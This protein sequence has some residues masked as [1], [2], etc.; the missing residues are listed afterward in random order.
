MAG[1]PWGTDTYPSGRFGP[2]QRFATGITSGPALDE[3]AN[4]AP[5]SSVTNL[6]YIVGQTGVSGSPYVGITTQLSSVLVAQK[7]IPKGFRIG[8]VGGGF[9]ADTCTIFGQTNQLFNSLFVW[10]QTIEASSSVTQ[11][12]NNIPYT[13]NGVSNSFI[14]TAVGDGITAVTIVIDL[15]VALTTTTGLLGAKITMQR[16]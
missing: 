1:G 11:L 2:Q 5:G 6:D 12:L 7:I 4:T 9:V 16:I 14:G 10:S 8:A 13:M 3:F 15:G